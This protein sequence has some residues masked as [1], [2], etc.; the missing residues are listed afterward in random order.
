MDEPKAP[1]PR[2]LPLP[3]TCENKKRTQ[4]KRILGIRLADASEKEKEMPTR[5]RVKNEACLS[6][7]YKAVETLGSHIGFNDN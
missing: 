7:L 3:R 6:W 4:G 5:N 1:R 2:L